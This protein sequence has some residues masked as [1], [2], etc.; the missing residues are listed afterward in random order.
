MTYIRMCVFVRLPSQHQLISCLHRVNVTSLVSV[1]WRHCC[2]LNDVTLVAWRLSISPCCSFHP[3][4]LH[5]S[6]SVQTTLILS[7][8][9]FISFAV[10]R[11]RTRTSLTLAAGLCWVVSI[12]WLHSADRFRTNRVIDGSD[13]FQCLLILLLLLLR[14]HR[15]ETKSNPRVKHIIYYAGYFI[16]KYNVS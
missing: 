4:S 13:W 11:C 12:R 6:L 10:I 14:I 15:N 9:N 8:V 16:N 7:S 5:P 3:R 2:Q 1:T